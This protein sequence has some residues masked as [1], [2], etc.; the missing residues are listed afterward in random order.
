MAPLSPVLLW[1][2]RRGLSRGMGIATIFLTLFV[3]ATLL[4]TLTLPSLAALDHVDSE[5][6]SH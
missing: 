1:F 5:A 6:R 3:I 2:E 4:L